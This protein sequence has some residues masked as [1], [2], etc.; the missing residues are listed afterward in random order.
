MGWREKL[1]DVAKAAV[2]W[3]DGKPD[4]NLAAALSEDVLTFPLSDRIE[5][6]RELLAGTGWVVAV[7]TPETVPWRYGDAW[8]GIQDAATEEALDALCNGYADGWNACRAAML[9][10]EG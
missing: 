1:A 8:D 2:F 10:D 5:L 6:V 9:G 7:T 4:R 3:C